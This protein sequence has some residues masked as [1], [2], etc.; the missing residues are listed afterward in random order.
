M[1]YSGYYSPNELRFA[2]RLELMNE[3]LTL[4]CTYSLI[5]FSAFVPDATTR[6]LCGW[7]L[8]ALV[9]LTLL[10][11]ISIMVITSLFASIRTCKRKVKICKQK[12]ALKNRIH[13]QTVIKLAN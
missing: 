6:Y 7:Y 3:T 2:N 1:L 12:K 5:V 11:N 4:V 10:V 9:V 13:K 8:I